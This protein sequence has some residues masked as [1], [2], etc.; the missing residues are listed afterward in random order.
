MPSYKRFFLQIS[1][2][3]CVTF[4]SIL[5]GIAQVISTEIKG[6]V[7]D[8]HGAILAGATVQLS[9]HLQKTMT[10]DNGF[11]SFH[12]IPPG[13][14]VVKVTM[15]G[16]E[17]QEKA[18]NILTAKKVQVSFSLKTS[19]NQLNEV[20][21]KGYKAIKGMGYLNDV[22]EGIIYSGKKTEVILL[23]SLNANTAQNNPR[24]VLGRIPGANYSETESSG[25]PSNGI[26]FRGLNPTQSV[27]TNTRQNG[28]NVAADIFG[29]PETYYLPPLEAVERIEVTRGAAS[30]QFGPQFGGVI[31]YIIKKGPTD[32]PLEIN[33]QQ[34]GGSFN[35]F[36]SFISAGG[37]LGKWNYYSFIQYKNTL[38][39]R[40]NS[41]VQQLS[42]FAGIN[43]QWF[44]QKKGFH[45]Y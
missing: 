5:P 35:L 25:F 29:Y 40:P 16:F 39:W 30:L 38:G 44:V 24:Q 11:Y 22:H 6:Q 2:V 19:S 21:I 34:T 8:E 15:G 10:D 7:T 23:D 43:Y 36:N 17:I 12:Q 42:G 33:I 27:E 14:Y 18:V 28:Y 41:D 45:S 37:Q 3:F 9:Y 32:K 31:N 20:V 26:G 13:S 4:L 1:C